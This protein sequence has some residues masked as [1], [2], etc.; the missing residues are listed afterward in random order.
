MVT[1]A[2]PA[3]GVNV[4]IK[5]SL[6]DGVEE[7]RAKARVIWRSEGYRGRGGVMG[8]KFTDISGAEQIEAYMDEA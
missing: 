2:P 6:T 4:D 3:V 1:A 5:F 8:I 7:V